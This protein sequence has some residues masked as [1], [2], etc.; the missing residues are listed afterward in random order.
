M[1]ANNLAAD[2]STKFFPIGV[3]QGLFIGNIII[4]LI[5]TKSLVTGPSPT[6]LIKIEAYGIGFSAPHFWVTF[7]VCLSSVI[8]TSQTT[9]AI[10]RILGKFRDDLIPITEG[11]LV[12]LPNT[13]NE[14]TRIRN[15]GIYSW[16][17]GRRADRTSTWSP[18]QWSWAI[19][20]KGTP[21]TTYP[22][23]RP[24]FPGSFRSVLPY[25]S[26]TLAASTGWLI[27]YL[28]PPVG[29][30]CRN[31]GELIVYLIWL[32]SHFIESVF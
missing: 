22:I 4:A 7:A 25:L 9:A 14:A 3:A 21:S 29:W 26:L 5:R 6:T 15:G 32:F 31:N 2:R 20:R 13:F 8:G 23:L 30:G 12:T 11:R 16:Q 28:V 19:S 24:S 17:P 27:S 10:P 18:R 1:A